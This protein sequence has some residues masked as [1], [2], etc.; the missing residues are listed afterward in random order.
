MN[1]AMGT[2]IAD[3]APPEPEQRGR[4]ESNGDSLNP[5]WE[6][7]WRT[8]RL[9]RTRHLYGHS[10]LRTNAVRWGHSNPSLDF[11]HRGRR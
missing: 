4:F 2:P 1:S 3:S 8:A 7:G 10:L 11:L 6:I 9:G 5:I